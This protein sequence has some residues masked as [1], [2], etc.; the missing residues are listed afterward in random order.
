M[1]YK[2]KHGLDYRAIRLPNVVG[3]G[4]ITHGY[5]EY[6][7][8]TIEESAR[9]NAYTV[10]V[11][12]Q[13]RIPVIHIQDAVRAFMELA[14]APL[15]RIRTANYITLGPAPIPTHADLVAV[16]R[17]KLPAARIDY[18]IN[19]PV[20]RLIDSACATAYDDSCAR[21]EWGW[22][23]QYGLQEMVDSFLD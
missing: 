3:P 14:S 6:F 23:H 4:A 16:V 12:P 21:K 18:Q 1:F 15:E 10:Y 11:K 2:R 20:Q 5:L 17:A 7:N 9:G 13:T 8:K 22:K 19:E